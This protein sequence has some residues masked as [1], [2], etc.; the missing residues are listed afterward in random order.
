MTSIRSLVAPEK[1]VTM[2]FPGFEGFTVDL[3]FLGR[4]AVNKLRKKCTTT[5]YSRQTH[6]PVD[7]LD[8]D[9]FAIEYAK[10]TIKGWEGLTVAYLEELLPTVEDHGM[11]PETE[12]PFSTDEAIALM[13]SSEYFDNWVADQVRELSNF[14]KSKQ[15][16]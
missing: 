5:K 16:K 10:A 11:D 15:E 6:R 2:D 1:T 7:Q 3:C 12:I 4:E 14:T 13:E 9:K 8:E